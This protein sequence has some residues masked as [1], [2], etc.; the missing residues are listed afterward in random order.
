MKCSKNY[1]KDQLQKF[2]TNKLQNGKK[3]TFLSSVLKQ[4]K[5]QHLSYSTKDLQQL[6]EDLV[7][8]TLSLEL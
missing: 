6:T 4:E 8:T 5:A 1:Q 7:Y 3:K 2:K